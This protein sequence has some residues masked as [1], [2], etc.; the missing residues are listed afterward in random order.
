MTQTY[1][2]GSIKPLFVGNV[3]K[4][5]KDGYVQNK[6]DEPLEKVFESVRPEHC[7]SRN[8]AV[9]LSLSED[10]ID[11]LGGFT[12]Y[13]FTVTVDSEVFQHDLAWYSKADEF[14]QKDDYDSAIECAKSYWNGEPY[15]ILKH[16][17]FEV[18]TNSATIVFVDS[19]DD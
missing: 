19:F 16:S 7:L 15:H 14:I 6:W 17:C 5:Q 12:D 3:L 8:E 9:F 4:P 11:A 2:H 1:F 10:D 18:L 13:I